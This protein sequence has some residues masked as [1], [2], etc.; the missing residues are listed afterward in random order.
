MVSLAVNA[1]QLYDIKQV[2]CVYNFI[3]LKKT[4]VLNVYSILWGIY[5]RAVLG[6]IMSNFRG[7]GGGAGVISMGIAV[8]FNPPL[9]DELIA[10]I[11]LPV[12]NLKKLLQFQKALF[13]TNIQR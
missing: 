4:E 5:R 1:Y 8:L 6:K 3:Y 11:R 2:K 12:W 13:S 9:L 10:D 7:G